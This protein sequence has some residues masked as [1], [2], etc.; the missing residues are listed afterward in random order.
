M[1]DQANKNF[2]ADCNCEREKRAMLDFLEKRRK[3]SLPSF[4]AL[5]PIFAASSPM[6]LAPESPVKDEDTG[7][8]DKVN[9]D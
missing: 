9:D 2:H 4:A 7:K 5:L 1:A 3:A 8:C 6:E